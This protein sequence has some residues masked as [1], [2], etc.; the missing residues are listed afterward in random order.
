[1]LGMIQIIVE[2]Y[3][4]IMFTLFFITLRGKEKEMKSE[5][6]DNDTYKSDVLD[7]LR[8]ISFNT[9]NTSKNTYFNKKK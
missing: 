3:L 8:K 9:L 4:S 6:I 7:F 2:I 5:K 1:M